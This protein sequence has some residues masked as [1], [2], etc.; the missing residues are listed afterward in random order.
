M[1][2]VNA[3]GASREAAVS[4]ERYPLEVAWCGACSLM[5]ILEAPAPEVIFG[6]YPYYSSQSRTMC[7]HAVALVE[8]YVEPGRKVFEIASNDGY[9]LGPAMARG[10]EVLGIEP[11]DTVAAAA[12]Q[13]G[14]RTE[15]VFF[16]A[17]SAAALR[18]RYGEADVVFALNVLA[19]V[20]DPNE[21]MAGVATLLAPKGRVHIEVPSLVELLR[22]TAFDTIYHEHHSYFSLTALDELTHRHGLQIANG[23]L[24]DIHGGSLHVE[25]GHASETKPSA[26]VG[27]MLQDE[28]K[29]FREEKFRMFA[30]RIESRRKWVREQIVDR[31]PCAAYG[32]AAKGVVLLNVFGLD[33]TWVDCIADISPYKQNRHVPGTG[34]RIVSPEE[35]A[36]RD[37]D[38]CLILPWNLMEE[39]TDRL[40]DFMKRGG[41]L[42]SSMPPSMTPPAAREPAL[43]RSGP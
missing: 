26:N 12:R 15:E 30:A 25:I 7:E 17:A 34:Q 2:L 32:A 38:V 1:P 19:H 39:I 36:E 16:D 18:E 35:L 6:G 21:V 24:I 11:A 5:Q 22:R 29:A 3:L 8:R 13:R 43:G 23:E 33:D 40:G 27:R 37:A 14:V 31:R 20:P 42:R 41:T 4:A 28:A 10:A 9:L